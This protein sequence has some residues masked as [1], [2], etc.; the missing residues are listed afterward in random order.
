MAHVIDQV[1]SKVRGS[2]SVPHSPS[3]RND[4]LNMSC[5]EVMM[6][7]L[8]LADAVTDLQC[9]VRCSPVHPTDLKTLR[10]CCKAFHRQLTGNMPVHLMYLATKAR[11]NRARSQVRCPF[12]AGAWF[13]RL[14]LGPMLMACRCGTYFEWRVPSI[15]FSRQAPTC[16]TCA[17]CPSSRRSA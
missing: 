13:Y 15:D 8:S 11:G 10:L 3:L 9:M 1:E 16:L 6:P 14:C 7:G 12:T 2:L 17:L 4:T 5:A